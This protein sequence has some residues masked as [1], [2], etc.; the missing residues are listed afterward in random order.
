M[1]YTPDSTA[2]WMKQGNKIQEEGKL[3]KEN[4]ERKE[5]TQ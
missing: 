2:T 1:T 5:H 3:R 4:M